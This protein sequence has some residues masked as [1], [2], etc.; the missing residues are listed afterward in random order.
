MS[1]DSRM[2]ERTFY[3]HSA[4]GAKE[5]H[6]LKDHLTS[7]QRLAAEFGQPL[8]LQEE[9]ALAGFLHD[10]GKYGDRFQDRLFGAARRIDHWSLGAWRALNCRSAAAALAVQGHHIGLQSA[11]REGVRGMDPGEL[12]ATHPLDL[13]L[14]HDDEEELLAR[15]EADGLARPDAVSHPVIAG[16]QPKSPGAMLDF[17]MVFSCLVDADYLDT[18]AH[19]QGDRTGKAMRAAGPDLRPEAALDI[20]TRHV[21]RVAA[22]SGA[23]DAMRKLRSDLWAACLAAGRDAP[24]L[25]TLAAPT[26]AGKT[27]AMLGFALRQAA[28]HRKRRIIVVI[29]YLSII[30][31][32]ARVLRDVFQSELGADYVLEH[33]SLTGTGQEQAPSDGERDAVHA[34]RRRARLA[35]ENWDA[36]L[37]VTTSVQF[38][39]SLFSNRP[40]ACRKLHRVAESVVLFDEVQTLPPWSAVP[41]L[42]ALAHLS[43]R[44]RSS[45]VFA[46][47]TQP[48]FS[49]LGDAVVALEG[50]AW[51]P[52]EMA[53]AE[54]DLFG[55]ARRVEVR[56][57]RDHVPLAWDALVSELAA[58][59][60]VLCI[61]NLKRH[62]RLVAEHLL[63]AAGREGLF[64]LSTAMCP[65]HRRAVLDEVRRRLAEGAACRLVATQCVEAGVDVDFPEVFRA[66]GPLEAVAQAAGRC[67][68]EGRAEVGHVT[69]FVPEEDVYPGKT[70]RLAANATRTLLEQHG[71]HLD[72]DDPARVKEYYEL[73]FTRVRPGDMKPELTDAIKSLHF[74]HVAEHYRL[75]DEA[76]VNVLVQYDKV[77]FDELVTEVSAT[78]LTGA[79]CRRA[80][81]H[82][83]SVFRDKASG[84]LGRMLVA[85]R[86]ADQQGSSDWFYCP[87]EKAYDDL[88]GLMPEAVPGTWIG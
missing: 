50:K 24:G 25:W 4:N 70:Y 86:L 43:E 52:R 74:K 36:P 56:W 3:A 64:H 51:Q 37:I 66:L 48:A 59:P 78:F 53:P 8:G 62:A 84:P 44:Y 73:F 68:R 79:W 19:F 34:A 21:E 38:L 17:R 33:H 35:A 55:R 87:E 7:V 76:R 23:S 31:Q 13:T 41:T 49:S 71:W 83:V 57:P 6:P 2:P 11:D 60:Q 45:V 82:A 46:T 65:L 12:A 16:K 75:I 18:E 29:P 28:T 27:L 9:A 67:N 72:I 81:P 58:R 85:I 26:G 39:E 15:L 14:S 1:D 42:G 22:G 54:L 5:W 20:L 40:S 88:W 61:V 69:V 30:E 80:Q 32:T 10:L 63:K 77:A 47:A